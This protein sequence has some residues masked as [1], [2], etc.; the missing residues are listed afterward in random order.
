M[1]KWTGLPSINRCS[2]TQRES[3]M[4]RTSEPWDFGCNMPNLLSKLPDLNVKPD[5][6]PRS[7]ISRPSRGSAHAAGDSPSATP[8]TSTLGGVGY[9]RTSFLA[10]STKV[11]SVTSR[12]KYSQN[13]QTIWRSLEHE[14][15]ILYSNSEGRP[16]IG[17]FIFLSATGAMALTF[18]SICYS[19]NAAMAR[20][21]FLTLL[22]TDSNTTIV[23]V[24]ALV[25][26]TLWVLSG[27]TDQVCHCLRHNQ[28][29]KLGTMFMEFLALS[30][31]ASLATLFRL[32][33]SRGS[34]GSSR[35]WAAQRFF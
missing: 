1:D 34:S 31:G 6:N 13:N 3:R 7:E 16:A 23:I 28:M 19:Y 14:E 24:N 35:Y 18:F 10:T 33:V 29:S 20:D 30:P 4:R 5:I 26:S 8:S 27:L 21:P 11:H 22:S 12:P 32:V 2:W 25:Q 9:E 15:L 17:A